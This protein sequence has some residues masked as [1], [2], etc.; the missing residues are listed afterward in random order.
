M[1]LAQ[2]IQP[3]EKGGHRFHLFLSLHTGNEVTAA[4]V[5]LWMYRY[6]PNTLPSFT[7]NPVWG[8]SNDFILFS[9]FCLKTR[10]LWLLSLLKLGQF[11]VKITTLATSLLSVQ[12]VYPPVLKMF[13]KWEWG[14]VTLAPGHLYFFF[15][16][17]VE[18]PSCSF[19]LWPLGAIINLKAHLCSVLYS[20]WIWIQADSS[21]CTLRS[22]R[23]HLGTFAESRCGQ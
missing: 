15:F 16:F 4:H 5:L 14:S 1:K 23:L 8:Y 20:I 2:E 19:H 9:I 11:G 10:Y 18:F 3:V 13:I 22:F 17:F 7:V 6:Y 21:V 12:F